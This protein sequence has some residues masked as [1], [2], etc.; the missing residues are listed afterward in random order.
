MK[1]KA[2]ARQLLV[3]AMV[4]C[5]DVDAPGAIEDLG[6][7]RSFADLMNKRVVLRAVGLGLDTV[8]R[9]ELS[10]QV[11]TVEVPVASQY[12]IEEGK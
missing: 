10:Y 6:S 9:E 12:H 11:Q 1:S 8:I 4:R 7:V 5:A 2:L 3:H